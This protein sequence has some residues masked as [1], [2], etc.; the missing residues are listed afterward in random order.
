MKKVLP[1]EAILAWYALNRS[2]ITPADQNHFFNTLQFVA[3]KLNNNSSSGGKSGS[4]T[5]NNKLSP[6]M[7]TTVKNKPHN[8]KTWGYTSWNKSC[9]RL[10]ESIVIIP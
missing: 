7:S 6:A 2:T 8:S 4:K 3:F 10:V 9:G 1:M 5:W